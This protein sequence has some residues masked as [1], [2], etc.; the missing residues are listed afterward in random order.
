LVN[1]V[2]RAWTIIKKSSIS[3]AWTIM[4]HM[5]LIKFNGMHETN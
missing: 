4:E 3:R 1:Q 5:R 2:F